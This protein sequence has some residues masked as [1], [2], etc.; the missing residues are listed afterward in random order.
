M[1]WRH[2]GIK[3]LPEPMMTPFLWPGLFVLIWYVLKHEHRMIHNIFAYLPVYSLYNFQL[4][5]VF[6]QLFDY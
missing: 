5:S 2:I 1:A 6:F 4:I 3:V